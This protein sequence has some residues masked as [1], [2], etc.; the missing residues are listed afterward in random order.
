MLSTLD[1]IIIKYR[2]F[3]ESIECDRTSH[4]R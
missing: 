1:S 3:V 2:T 4:F